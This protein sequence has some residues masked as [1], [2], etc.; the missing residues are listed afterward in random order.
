M[1]FWRLM[2]PD[3]DSDY[4]G[5]YINGSL[6]HPF[7]LPGVDCDVCGQTWGG[8]RV[9]SYEYPESLRSHKKATDRWPIPRSQHSALQE[10]LL[11]ELGLEGEPFVDLRPGDSFQPC[12]LD[13]PSR[14]R[15]DFLWSSIGVLV[16]SERIKESLV[17]LCRDEIA[18][19]PITLRKVGNREAKLAPPMPSSGEPEDIIHEVPLLTDKAGVGPYYEIFPLKESDVPRNRPVKGVCSGCHREDVEV[20][21]PLDVNRPRMADEIWRGDS[22]FYLATTLYIIVTDDIKEVLTRIR[23]NNINF[24]DPA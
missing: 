9:L 3:Y 23:P 21:Y 1:R 8:S 7:G 2:S 6:E 17:S 19:R 5:S 16:V 13:V 14:P 20:I 11:N 22:V 15:A 10:Q 18:V 12:Y 24:V 4:R